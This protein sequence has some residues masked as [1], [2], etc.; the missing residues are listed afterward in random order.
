MPEFRNASNAN[1]NSLQASLRKLAYTSQTFGRSYFALAYTYSH[2][3]DNAS[4]FRN[5]NSQVPYYHPDYFRTSSDFDLRH[6]LVFSGG[7][8]LP[9]VSW[10][11]DAIGFTIRAH[12]TIGNVESAFNTE[13]HQFEYNGSVYRAH[14]RNV[15]LNGEAGKY[16]YTVAGIESHQVRPLYKRAIDTRTN[17]LFPSVPLKQIA[18]N[19]G[20]PP[21]ILRLGLRWRDGM[22]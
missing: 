20:F 14:V 4:G 3:I 18:K 22:G 1:F 5:R 10:I 19:A 17:K 15:R 2:N 16:V 21:R 13:I 8:D 6:R 7:W 11:S 9:V 12:G